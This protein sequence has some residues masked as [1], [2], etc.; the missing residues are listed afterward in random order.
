MKTSATIAALAAAAATTASAGGIDRAANNNDIIFRSGNYAEIGISRT[1]PDVTGTDRPSALPRRYEY[2]GVADSFTLVNFGIKYDLNDRLSLAFTGQQD[3]G[4]DINYDGNPGTSFLG[5]TSAVA[6]TYALSLL[7]RYKLTENF[8]VHG[9]LR[10]DRADGKI[11]LDGLAYGGPTVF[12]PTGAPLSAAQVSALS[13]GARNSNA[14]SGYQVELDEDWGY[15]YQLGAAYEVPEIALR[16]AVTYTSKITHDFGTTESFSASG[17]R[18][19][20]FTGG[21]TSV[22]TP[23]S[24]NVNLQS[25]V[26]KNTL[27][28]ANYRWADW[29]EFKINPDQFRR[30][31]GA[32]LVS[33][34]DAHTY[35]IGVAHRFTPA[36]AAR[37]SVVRDIVDGDNL[38]SPLSPTKGYTAFA[39]GGSYTVGS[40]EYSAGVRYFLLGD[41]QPET[42]TPDVARADFTDNDAI[43]FGF[44]IGYSF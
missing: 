29:S 30:A 26:A 1:I 16:L 34:D 24:V 28:F 33:I 25:G 38:V 31:T 39:V 8:S 2:D 18:S 43:A 32:Q 40:V 37:A 9:G 11:R 23:Q 21:T 6:D 36:F 27:V 41:A 4:S 42:G 10:A 12:G 13:G 44:K 5:G 15:G 20:T 35:E 22:D 3:Y 14:V 19:A 17:G 7:A